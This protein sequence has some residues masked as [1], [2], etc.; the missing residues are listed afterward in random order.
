MVTGMVRC[1]RG[2]KAGEGEQAAAEESFHQANV[3]QPEWLQRTIRG[4]EYRRER[5]KKKDNNRRGYLQ[6]SKQREEMA[7]CLQK[8]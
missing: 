6:E 7:V 1:S 3:E 8:R 4:G 5:E 2:A